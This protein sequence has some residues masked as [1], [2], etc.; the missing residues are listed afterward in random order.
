MFALSFPVIGEGYSACMFTAMQRPF[1]ESLRQKFAESTQRVSGRVNTRLY[2]EFL[3]DETTPIAIVAAMSA[4][5]VVR[6]RVV[7]IRVGV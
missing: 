2:F 7:I 3:H 1:E 4:R 6:A 5:N